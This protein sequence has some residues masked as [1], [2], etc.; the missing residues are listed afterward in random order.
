MA[1]PVLTLEMFRGAAHEILQAIAA[2]RKA[3]DE[4]YVD[5]W[6]RLWSLLRLM[7]TAGP[8]LRL[9]DE[10]VWSLKAPDVTRPQLGRWLVGG[11]L[12]LAVIMPG[13]AGAEDLELVTD[14]PRILNAAQ[15]APPDD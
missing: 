12:W 7:K 9:H 8:R 4:L 15:V 2:S 6:N 13:T 1:E 3:P 10:G 5:Q 11:N 14:L